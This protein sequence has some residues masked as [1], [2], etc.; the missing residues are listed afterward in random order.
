MVILWTFRLGSK[1]SVAKLTILIMDHLALTC[2]VMGS[3]PAYNNM[4][5]GNGH[6]MMM[7]FLIRYWCCALE[8]A[9][10]RLSAIKVQNR[11]E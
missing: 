3:N 11:I 8:S 6:G 5:L 10:Q 9:W 1:D 2:L 7:I 4:G